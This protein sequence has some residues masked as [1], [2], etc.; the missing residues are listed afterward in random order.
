MISSC[1]VPTQINQFH[2]RHYSSLRPKCTG[3]FTV[4]AVTNVRQLA[5][6]DGFA[7]VSGLYFFLPQLHRRYWSCALTL[8]IQPEDQTWLREHHKFLTIRRL[9]VTFIL[10]LEPTHRK[11]WS[12]LFRARSNFP[13]KNTKTQPMLAIQ[14]YLSVKSSFLIWECIFMPLS[15]IFQ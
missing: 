4:T 1:A 13:P 5:R 3:H 9:A 8:R 7:E 12:T 15:P 6:F 2:T 10:I 14:I 11:T